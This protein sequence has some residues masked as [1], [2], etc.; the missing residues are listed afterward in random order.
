MRLSDEAE[1]AL[2]NNRRLEKELK[3]ARAGL[4]DQF[5]MAALT[6]LAANPQRPP[7]ATEAAEMAYKL[8]AAAMHERAEIARRAELRPGCSKCGEPH[9]RNWLDGGETCPRCR[10]VQ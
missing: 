7:S 1:I 5:A 3:A 4:L 2:V 6:G 10:L 9:G 8:A